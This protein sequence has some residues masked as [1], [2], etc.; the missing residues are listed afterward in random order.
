MLVSISCIWFIIASSHFFVRNAA[1]ASVG[2]LTIL[3]DFTRANRLLLIVVN[4][5][6]VIP[7]CSFDPY[8]YCATLICLNATGFPY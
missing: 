7:H 1:A 4:L 2:T 8:P 3:L 5:P 6:H